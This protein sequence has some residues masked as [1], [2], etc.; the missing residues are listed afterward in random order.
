[1]TTLKINNIIIPGTS[2][3]KTRDIIIESEHYRI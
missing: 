3:N 2:F 1:M